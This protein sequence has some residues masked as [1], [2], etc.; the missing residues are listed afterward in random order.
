MPRVVSVSLMGSWTCFF[1]HSFVVILIQLG[2]KGGKCEGSVCCLEL[3]IICFFI[4]CFAQS[5]K[6]LS[7]IF[8][9]SRKNYDMLKG[10]KR[11]ILKIFKKTLIRCLMEFLIAALLVRH[12]LFSCNTVFLCVCQLS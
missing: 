6:F 5:F 7:N 2:G 11:E 4:T 1:K 9:F 12:C 10:M 3:E 8:F